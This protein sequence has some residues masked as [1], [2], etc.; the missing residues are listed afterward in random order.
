MGQMSQLIGSIYEMV[1]PALFVVDRLVNNYTV[2]S[3]R[4]VIVVANIVT[5]R[6][7]KA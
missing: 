6:T 2:R 3:Y 1:E 7:R 5:R 4:D